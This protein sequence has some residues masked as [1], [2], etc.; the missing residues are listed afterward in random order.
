M[1][2]LLPNAP[3]IRSARPSLLDFGGVLVPPGGGVVQQLLRP[4]RFS[5]DVT[6]PS[7]RGVDLA[8]IYVLSLARAKVE[9]AL[10][11]FPQDYKNQA[12][13]SPV[14]NGAGQTGSTLHLKGFTPGAPILAGQFF[15]IIFGGRRYLHMAAADVT[16]ASD[17][18]AVLPI[19]PMLRISPNDGAVCEFA[20][21]MIEGYLA[22]NAVQWQLQAAPYVDITFTITEMA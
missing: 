8:R 10:F 7:T 4:S 1:S 5:I 3:G 15:S 12:T 18:T 14:V 19:A 22:G 6:L 13:G 11:A 20:Q 9:G 17:G 2:I 21:P 16:V